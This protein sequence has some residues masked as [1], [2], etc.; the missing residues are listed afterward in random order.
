MHPVPK[1]PNFS[2]EDQCEGPVCGLDEVGRG[3][4]AGPVV[5]AAVVLWRDKIPRKIISKINDSKKLIARER[6]YL[7]DK[8]Y[9]FADV[10]IAECS[11]AEID[12]INILR[13]SLRAME[14]AFVM[15]RIKP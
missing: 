3:P 14:K 9:E 7:F 15:L 10:A 8:I 2:F 12:E 13:A 5:A 1:K 4:L 11:V 6:A